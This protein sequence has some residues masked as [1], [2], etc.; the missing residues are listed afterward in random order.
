MPAAKPKRIALYARVSTKDKGQN[1][2]NQLD[3][4]REAAAKINDS[5]IVEEYVEYESASG[6]VRRKVFDRMMEDGC[7]DGKF[8][9][10]LFWSL[11]R[12]SREGAAPTLLALQRLTKAGVAWRSLQEDFLD[13]TALG[14]FRD[15]VVALMAS[16]AKLETQR[17]S[18]RAKAAVARLRKQG[19]RVGK[20]RRE[21]P[22][23]KLME[24]RDQGLSKSA[25]AKLFG[26]SRAT[27]INR[28]KEAG[29]G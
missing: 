13:T 22:A 3:P 2:D 20:P 28:L 14:P 10:L 29:S 6:R 4:L 18:E 26:V 12:F 1:P 24:L 25:L 16:I 23:E 15:V 9:L 27:I 7:R 5:K 8:D 17:R 11:D 19:K 21:V